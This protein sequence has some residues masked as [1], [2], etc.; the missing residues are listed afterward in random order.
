MRLVRGSRATKRSPFLLEELEVSVCSDMPE[1]RAKLK[2]FPLVFARSIICFLFCHF[3]FI[4]SNTCLKTFDL[5]LRDLVQVKTKWKIFISSKIFLA[6]FF[7]QAKI[8]F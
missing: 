4:G 2:K 6:S 1:N 5:F 3:G 7:S 8:F